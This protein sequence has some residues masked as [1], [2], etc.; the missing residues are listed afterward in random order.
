MGKGD[1]KSKKGKIF[2]GSYGNTRRRKKKNRKFIVQKA[3]PKSVAAPE[4]TKPM[5]EEQMAGAT[6]EAAK[7]KVKRAAPKKKS[8]EKKEPKAAKK[9]SKKT[10]E[11]ENPAAE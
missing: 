5:A 9:T 2:M 1:K 8:A 3:A 6:A 7:P 11:G 4:I 10:G